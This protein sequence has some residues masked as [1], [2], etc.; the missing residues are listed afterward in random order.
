MAI[1]TGVLIMIT[2]TLQAKMKPL[3]CLP[4]IG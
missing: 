1:A 4:K 2:P 3:G